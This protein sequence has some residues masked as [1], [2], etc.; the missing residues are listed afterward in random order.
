M[1]DRLRPLYQKRTARGGFTCL[2][3]KKFYYCI[4]ILHSFAG[5]NCMF[6]SFLC[7]KVKLLLCFV[8][9]YCESSCNLLAVFLQS[10]WMT[11]T[12][13]PLVCIL[14]RNSYS[15]LLD[16]WLLP[17]A[18]FGSVLKSFWILYFQVQKQFIPSAIDRSGLFII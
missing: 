14:Q 1:S 17:T 15:V 4:F 12:N 3:V 11:R 6:C 13:L 8:I 10:S 18:Q 16:D 2:Y 9:L 5:E 7:S